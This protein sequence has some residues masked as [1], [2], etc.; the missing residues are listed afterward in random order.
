MA[1]CLGQGAALL[2][3]EHDS[4]K[5]REELLHPTE[6]PLTTT[7]CWLLLC[8]TRSTQAEAPQV[9]A[10]LGTGPA[11]SNPP[12][13]PRGGLPSTQATLPGALHPIKVT[14]DQ[15]PPLV[16]GLSAWP[17]TPVQWASYAS[18]DQPPI[19]CVS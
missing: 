12:S 13:K 4:P 11:L 15:S 2:S 14:A 1:V 5:G 19:N 8:A 17:K 3:P 9:S 6:M 16:R 7:S 10:G 18:G